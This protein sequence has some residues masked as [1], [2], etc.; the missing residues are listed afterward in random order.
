MEELRCELW[1]AREK[2]APQ[3]LQHPRHRNQHGDA[4]TLDQ[5]NQPAWVGT[6]RQVQLSSQQGRDPEAHELPKHMAERQRVQES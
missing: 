3:Q 6:T 5:R 4:L 1:K 2:M